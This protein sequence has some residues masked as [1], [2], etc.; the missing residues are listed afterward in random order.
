MGSIFPDRITKD[1]EVTEID[2][3]TEEF[4]YH[5]ERLTEQRAEQIAAEVLAKLPG[6]PSLSGPGQHSPSVTVRLPAATKRRLEETAARSGRR[7]S[8]IIRAAVEEYLARG[9]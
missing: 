3:D 8:D 9:A 1:V 6:R 5:G 2:L 4:Y 7:Q